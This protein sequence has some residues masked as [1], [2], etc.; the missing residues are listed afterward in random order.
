VTCSSRIYLDIYIEQMVSIIYDRQRKK[1][2]A[3]KETNDSLE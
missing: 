2:M 3:M 1:E